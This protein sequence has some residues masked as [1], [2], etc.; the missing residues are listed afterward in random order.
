MIWEEKTWDEHKECFEHILSKY[1]R[2]NFKI[3]SV[4]S[5]YLGNTLGV[6]DKVVFA[7]SKGYNAPLRK[8]TI[9]SF[10]EIKFYNDNVIVKANIVTHLGRYTQKDSNELIKIN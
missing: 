5:D 9:H 10:T 8:G 4:M 6:G 1:E 7:T 2:E 3:D